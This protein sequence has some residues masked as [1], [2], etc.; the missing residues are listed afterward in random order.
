MA[1]ET[2]GSIIKEEHVKTVERGILP[3]TFVLENLGSFPGYYGANL[4]VDR[5]P[6]SI[7]LVMT[8]RESTEKI[9]R[10]T[11]DIKKKTK[12]E[13][14][15]TPASLCVHNT[16]YQS[17][18]LRYLKG[19]DHIAELQEYYRD[20][21]IIFA[22]SKKLEESAIIQIKKL[23]KVDWISDKILKDHEEPM[24][25]LKINEQLNWSHFKK[26]TMQVRNN[27]QLSAF[28][29][30]LAVIYG[31]EVLDLVRIYSTSLNNEE[32]EQLHDKYE[33]IIVKS[34]K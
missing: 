34:L 31:S 17:I 10:I 23:F 19:F 3:N 33:E 4:P 2:F 12:L 13:Y 9:L 25:Y 22:K 21:G 14:E 26:V 28:D 5:N 8:Q 18:R 32:L 6:D 15:G 16:T 1:L 7:F 24:Y 11:H 29:A 30:A 27:I 20:Y